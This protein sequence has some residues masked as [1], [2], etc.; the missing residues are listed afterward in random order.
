MERDRRP[1]S[2]LDAPSGETLPHAT[3]GFLSVCVE[4]VTGRGRDWWP[5]PG[6]V[7]TA[8]RGHT[9]AELAEAIDVAFGRW[10]LAHLRMFVLP[11]GEDVSFSSWRDGPAFPGTR[12]GRRTR[13]DVLSDDAAFA[14]VFDL[15]EDWTHLCTVRRPEPSAV[16]SQP[17]QPPR[18][19][20]G[21]GDLPDQYGRHHA[22][23]GISAAAPRAS[24]ALLSDLPP[25][26]PSWG[27]RDG[28][29]PHR[30]GSTTGVAAP[31]RG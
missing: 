2:A 7:F 3:D 25:I 10:D 23:D 11:G 16:A 13:L 28:R 21:W 24:S 15:G 14:Y 26:L 31:S 8:H 4:L 18:P 12:D 20:R 29:S 9:F 19:H 22:D 5:R 6:R 27:A 30:A 1:T 17:S